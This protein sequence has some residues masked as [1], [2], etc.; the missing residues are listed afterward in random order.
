MKNNK[1]L[2][3]MLLSLVS[4]TLVGVIA[5]VT[6]LNSNSG[7]ASGREQ[8]ID[9]IVKSSVDV[10]EIT[11]NLADSDYIKIAFT[12]QTDSKHGK[13]ELEKRNFQVNNII[14]T[15]LSE[16]TAAQFE[17]KTGKEN[18]QEK[19]KTRINSIMHDGTI[20]NVYI[21]SSIIQ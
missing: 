16:L 20:E 11:T 1:A 9:D 18:L 7:K 12:I 13:E 21:T 8:S 2:T 14:L 6:I 5:L 10:P 19:L 3:I 17:G 4:I 15:E